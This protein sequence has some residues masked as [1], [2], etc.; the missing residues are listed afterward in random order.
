MQF[1]QNYSDVEKPRPSV[2]DHFVPGLIGNDGSA[3]WLQVPPSQMPWGIPMADQPTIVRFTAESSPSMKSS[4]PC[5]Y[6]FSQAK[7][8][9]DSEDIPLPVKQHITEEKMAAHLSQLHISSDYTAHQPEPREDEQQ[10]MKRLVLCD[11]LRKLKQEPI[12]PPA[13]LSRLEKRSMALVLWQPPARSSNPALSRGR[14][15]SEEDNNNTSAV[16]LNSISTS[17][18]TA[19]EDSM[20]EL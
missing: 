7:R 1:A 15:Q 2:L 9:F 10:H 5:I 17:G 11:E 16:D 6:G 19:S 20:M 8:K 4:E 13:L 12:L 3:G 18:F 14:I